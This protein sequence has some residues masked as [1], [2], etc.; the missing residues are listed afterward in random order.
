MKLQNIKLS[1]MRDNNTEAILI[2]EKIEKCVKQYNISINKAITY[3]LSKYQNQY[4]KRILD[5]C[6][7]VYPY[8]GE[9][10]F[11]IFIKKND[12]FQKQINQFYKIGNYKKSNLRI[13]HEED[14]IINNKKIGVQQQLILK[15][16]INKHIQLANE[17]IDPDY[18]TQKKKINKKRKKRID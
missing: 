16:N 2:I 15:N 9:V 1:L 6:R 17:I 14:N 8:D 18:L 7:A 4:Q 5:I 12:E 3:L 13:Q 10:D 11:N